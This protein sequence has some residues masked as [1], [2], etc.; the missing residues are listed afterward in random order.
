MLSFLKRHGTTMAVAMVTAAI[1][2]AAPAIAETVANADKVDGFDAVSCKATEQGRAG[3]LV[4]TCA[5][6]FLPNG[7]VKKAANADHL[8]GIDSGGFYR[9]G[10]TVANSAQLGGLP[11]NR[12]TRVGYAISTSSTT[13]VGKNG[14]VLSASITVPTTGFLLLHASSDTYNPKARD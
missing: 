8:D 9:S 7:L 6:G 13:R 12:L 10:S 4:A 11:A 14:R 3:K 1:T 5:S 2:A